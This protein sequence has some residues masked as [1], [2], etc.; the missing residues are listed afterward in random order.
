MFSYSLILFSDGVICWLFLLLQWQVWGP[1]GAILRLLVRADA[2]HL[3]SS[4]PGH[5]ALPPEGR[6]LTTKAGLPPQFSSYPYD[7]TPPSLCYFLPL[8]NFVTPYLSTQMPLTRFIVK[9][10]PFMLRH[11]LHP[12]MAGGVLSDFLKSTAHTYG[13]AA[14]VTDWMR[15]MLWSQRSTLAFWSK[16]KKRKMTFTFMTIYR[17]LKPSS[18]LFQTTCI[19]LRLLAF[20]RRPFSQTRGTTR[21]CGYREKDQRRNETSQDK[22]L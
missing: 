21:P 9:R 7:T 12:T 18:H 8:W 4:H 13:L 6:T 16:Q 14:V 2:Q 15:L 5:P 20:Y 3:S 17:K 10:N 1:A 11:Y 19:A 22:N